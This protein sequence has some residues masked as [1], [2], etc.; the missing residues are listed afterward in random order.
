MLIY[1]SSSTNECLE[2]RYHLDHLRLHHNYPL[3]PIL[4]HSLT[5]TIQSSRNSM[6]QMLPTVR[7]MLKVVSIVGK[8]DASPTCASC[9]SIIRS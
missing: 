1:E 2:L 5:S 8:V 6:S 3:L 7:A 4:P 9:T